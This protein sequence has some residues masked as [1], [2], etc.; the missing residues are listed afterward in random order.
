M[1]ATEDGTA[2]AAADAA[3]QIIAEAGAKLGAR[4]IAGLVKL[5][6]ARALVNEAAVMLITA[7]L[8]AEAATAAEQLAAARADREAAEQAIAPVQDTLAQL[9]AELTDCQQRA[10]NINTVI[11]DDMDLTARIEARS[12][13][14]AFAGETADL[15]ARMT[16]IR[17]TM[18]APLGAELGR[19]R[20]AEDKAS[21]E[22][23]ALV[24]AADDPLSHPRARR[25]EGYTIW[26]AHRA[27][28]VLA[29]GEPRHPDWPAARSQLMAV[30]RSSGIGAE[31]EK[32]A[33]EAYR[34]GDPAALAVA[35]TT[36][37]LANGQTVIAEP[38]KPPVVYDGRATRQQ[39]AA[40]PPNHGPDTTPAAGVM[41]QAWGAIQHQTSPGLW[42][43]P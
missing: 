25:T 36:Q 4:R 15:K 39:L 43:H 13:K 21:I 3:Q 10:A 18:L 1:T 5:A 7:D 35:G 31:V 42:I 40:A 17:Q 30:L 24:N 16:M 41:A 37:H 8:S 2:Q 34:A 29:T 23:T 28:E 14:A 20:A 9:E 33:I 22:A 27:L 32:R 38:G 12:L 19:A 26:M 6:Q 11:S